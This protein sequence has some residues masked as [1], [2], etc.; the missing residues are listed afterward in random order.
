MN[1][2]FAAVQT[3]A[4]RTYIQTAF[5]KK[6]TF[7]YWGLVG[8]AETLSIRQNSEIHIF[9]VTMLSDILYTTYVVKGRAIPLTGRGGPEG[10]ETS[11]FPHFLDN[12]LAD[13]GEASLT[14]RP[15]SERFL[16]LI[17][18][19]RPQGHSAAGRFRSIEKAND[20]IG[21]RTRGLPACSIVPQPTTLPRAPQ[22]IW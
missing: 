3:L 14:R 1:T 20:F 22:R 2:I 15:S 11:R 6:N 4:R 7:S 10:C 17:S 16:V 21:T 12:Q 18:V 9:T 13:G 8:G 19:S 5:Q